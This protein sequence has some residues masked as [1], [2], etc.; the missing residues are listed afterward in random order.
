VKLRLAVL[1]VFLAAC[2]ARPE[3]V[4]DVRHV[5]IVDFSDWHGQLEPVQVTIDGVRRSLGGAAALKA[6]VDRERQRNPGGTLLVTAGDAVG[7]TPPLSSFLDDVPAIEVLNA[8]GLDIDTLGNHN[9]DRGI[10]HLRRLTALA[11]FPYVAANIVGPDGQTLAP[12]THV[13][14]R[15]GVR[16]GV[17][18]IGNPETPIVVARDRVA[19]WRFLDPAPVIT[20]HAATLR[21]NGAHL[22]IVLAHV[23]AT[24]VTA[25]G[26]P[27][28]ILGDVARAIRGV[29]VLIGDHTGVA[30]NARVGDTLVV[31]N[32]SRGLQFA[33][34]DLE[35]D[36]GP[37]RLM[38]ASAVHRIPFADEIVPD[39]ALEAQIEGYR[40]R[41]RPLLDRR[42][43]EA[44]FLVARA[45]SRESALGNFVAD[46]LRAAYGAQLALINSGGIRDNLPA[47]YR[48]GDRALRRPTPGY[49]LGP[50]WDVVRGD[51]LAAL[52]FNNVA[53][54]FKITGRTLWQALENSVAP[55]LIV[56]GRFA[57]DSGRFLQISGF[58]FRF[59]P[60]RA[61][62]RRVT[63]VR[64]ADGAPIAPDD[65]EYT[66]VTVDFMYDG[67][68]GYTMLNNGTGTTRE[69]YSEVLAQSLSARP[70][71]ARVEGRIRIEGE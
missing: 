33:V 40:V 41:V 13:F 38:R 46:T 50:P 18:G 45:G 67:G 47:S 58:A 12:P 44:A 53:V 23:G 3:A 49:A 29:D 6:Y 22:V 48:P 30:V 64:L 43:G 31:A 60:R 54:T 7:A 16:V 62:G 34:I 8:M 55:G 65:R 51:I 21:Q 70:V 24:A 15:N 69:P 17:I 56:D 36:L 66:A 32:R 39:S 42:L 61:A 19:G 11:R 59:D 63:L 35:Y 68:D 5:T 14:T 26:S 9:F 71:S 4:S 25:D 20:A 10:A 28:G 2:G 52:P 27:L 57:T 1:L 37:R